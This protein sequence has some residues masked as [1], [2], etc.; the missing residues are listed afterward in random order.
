[1]EL[2]SSQVY[3]SQRLRLQYVEWGKKS[4]RPVILLHGGRD[5]SRSW[6]WVAKKLCKEWRVIAPDL[7]GHGDSEWVN[8]GNYQMAGYLYD[9][10]QLI[11]QQSLSPVSVVA[12]SLGAMIALRYTGLYPDRINKLIAIEGLGLSQKNA[13]IERLNSWIEQRHSL[14]SRNVKKYK[15]FDDAV[16]RMSAANSHLS[17]DTAEHLT[18]HGIK[19]NEDGTYSWKFDN[20]VR[21]WPPYDIPQNEL[22]KLWAQITC[23]TFLVGGKDSWHEDPIETGRAKLFR[24]AKVK[25]FDNSGHW[26]HHDRRNEF[27]ELT[28]DFLAEDS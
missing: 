3:Y 19:Q 8:D 15:T 25:I 17:T 7:R 27:I 13:I 9:L 2:P 16:E 20:Y 12:H 18:R 5:H 21:N 1:M 14:S 6:D 11:S 23:P 22:N 26:V 24:N 10:D 4:N 28:I